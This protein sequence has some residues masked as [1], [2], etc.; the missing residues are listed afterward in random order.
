MASG[1]YALHHFW[2]RDSHDTA[3]E[4]GTLQT[5]VADETPEA[6]P[7]DCKLESIQETDDYVEFCYNGITFRESMSVTDGIVYLDFV[8][9]N[10]QSIA[11]AYD[12]ASMV[13]TLTEPGLEGI[14]SYS[15]NLEHTYIGFVTVIDGKEWTFTYTSKDDVVSYYM[16][17]SLGRLDKNISSKSAVFTN[18]YGLFSG[19][20]YIWAKTIPLLKNYF[21]LGSGADSFTLIFPQSDYLSAY[22]GGYENMIISK[23]H[24]AYLQIAVQTGVL[25]LI[26]LL[27][28]YLWYTRKC[29]RLYFMKK[30]NTPQ[31]AFAVAV[32][33]G[34]TGFLTVLLAND[35]TICVTPIFSA[36][37]GIGIVL[38]KLNETKIMQTEH[39]LAKKEKGRS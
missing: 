32:F 1:F 12:D 30:I 11:Y 35:S 18:Y 6:F 34:T 33:A 26:L 16:M 27:L 37:M 9:A 28:F 24:N 39:F 8:N 36:L 38:N 2:I 15:V 31:Q 5:V 21:I 3:P 13:Y 10:G 22:K 14:S 19:R 7:A 29:I 25:S 4:A 17:N 20:G 23:P